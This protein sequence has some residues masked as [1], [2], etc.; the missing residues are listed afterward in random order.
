MKKLLTFSLFL[1]LTTPGFGA[2]SRLQQFS[3]LANAAIKQPKLVLGAILNGLRNQD[4]MIHKALMMHLTREN[5]KREIATLEKEIG[6]NK[7]TITEKYKPVPGLLGETV[8]PTVQLRF[9]PFTTLSKEEQLAVL[10]SQLSSLPEIPFAEETLSKF[11]PLVKT[12]LL[13]QIPRTDEHKNEQKY[14]HV[15]K[16]VNNDK[17]I[18]KITHPEPRKFFWE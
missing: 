2:A 3:I 5:T 14:P 16:L 4:I 8:D 9:K 10:H 6:L 12:A 7:N 15:E 17:T 11:S 13:A 18:K 1:V